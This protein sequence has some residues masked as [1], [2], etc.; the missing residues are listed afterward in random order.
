MSRSSRLIEGIRLLVPKKVD[1]HVVSLKIEW[2]QLKDRTEVLNTL[3]TKLASHVPEIKDTLKSL[4]SLVAG[5]SSSVESS[6]KDLEKRQN[7]N[8][9]WLG[10]W[11]RA[12]EDVISRY[13]KYL[14]VYK[15]E[16]LSSEMLDLV[17]EYDEGL[18]D[19]LSHLSTISVD[20]ITTQADTVSNISDKPLKEELADDIDEL[21]K[22]VISRISKAIESFTKLEQPIQKLAGVSKKEDADE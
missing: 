16:V 17:K 19:T 18:F 15:E 10:V 1:D 22:T 20:A 2:G 7:P 9:K 4:V 11:D 14:T 13:R 6:L 21:V 3:S 5:M 8:P 12:F